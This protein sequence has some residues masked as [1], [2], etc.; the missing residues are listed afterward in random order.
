MSDL[1]REK[2]K[3][4]YES[5]VGEPWDDAGLYKQAW[6]TAW[7]MSWKDSRADLSVT[8]PPARDSF[9]PNI[10]DECYCP[11]QLQAAF[12]AAGVKVISST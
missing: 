4:A 7:E 1:M 2:M 5:V 11:D 9:S 6:A 10:G 8:L 3:A 12:D